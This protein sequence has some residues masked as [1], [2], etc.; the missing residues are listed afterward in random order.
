MVSQSGEAAG[1]KT[2]VKAKG[3]PSRLSPT[4]TCYYYQSIFFTIKNQLLK[5]FFPDN[6]IEPIRLVGND[7]ATRRIHL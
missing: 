6:P 7:S 4:Q 3:N 5:V 2:L 1:K